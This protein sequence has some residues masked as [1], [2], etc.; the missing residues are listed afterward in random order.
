MASQKENGMAFEW[1]I[2]SELARQTG[3]TILENAYSNIPKVSF[4]TGITDARRSA[5]VRAAEVSVRHILEKEQINYSENFDGQIYFNSDAA[6]QQGDVRDVLL[7][8]SGKTIGISCKS[9]HEALKHSR[10]SG[11]LDFVNSWGL[12]SQ[13]CSDTYWSEISP[14]FS[15][16][17]KIRIESNA[18]A[19]WANVED[20]PARFY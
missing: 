11:P 14:L 2:G 13:G 15:E 18:S 4:Y 10:L 3:A 12:D 1:A 19:L 9:N 20:K 5:F 7:S 6:G 16:L 8:F 17:K